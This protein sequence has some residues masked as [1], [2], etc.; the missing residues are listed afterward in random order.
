MTKPTATATIEGKTYRL[1]ESVIPTGD[2]R[3]DAAKAALKK[4]GVADYVNA[5]PPRARNRFVQIFI[6]L[7]GTAQRADSRL[8]QEA[9]LEARGA[10]RGQ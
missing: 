1:A 5:R 9:L 6:M 8:L 2:S 4:H 3:F 10:G 7:D